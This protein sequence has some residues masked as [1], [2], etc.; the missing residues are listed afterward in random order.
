[1]LLFLLLW[2]AFQ[3]GVEPASAKPLLLLFTVLLLFP[4][5]STPLSRIPEERLGAWPIGRGQRVCLGV[6]S[7][8]LSPILWIALL[9][10]G[11][12]RNWTLGLFFVGAAVVIQAMASISGRF[13][14]Q[15]LRALPRMPGKLGGLMQVYLRELCTVLDVYA[16]LLLSLGGVL[17]RTWSPVVG[18]VIAFTLSTYAQC[19]FGLELESSAMLRYGLLPLRGWEILLAKDAVWFAIVAILVAPFGLGAGL[20]FGFVSLAIGH[21]TSLFVWAPQV[22]WRFTGGRVLAGFLQCLFG[23]VFGFATFQ[24]GAAFLLAAGAVWLASLWCY[25]RVWDGRAARGWKSARML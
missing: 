1:L 6:C 11:M 2:G 18:M 16:A 3:S 25:G 12:S 5:S 17:T 4:L 8:V 22:R 14:A 19:L 21:H 23:F 13:Q 20:A 7:L 9:I 15:P 10:V 24:R